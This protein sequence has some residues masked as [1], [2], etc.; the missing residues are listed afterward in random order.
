MSSIVILL[1]VLM[2]VLI[3]FFY[4]GKK[5]KLLVKQ[6]EQETQFEQELAKAQIEMREMTLTYV[7]QELHDDIGQ[8]LSVAKMMNNQLVSKSNGDLK[9][10][11]N[12]ISALLGESIQ[13]IRNM[14]KTY[15]RTD[16]AFWSYWIFKTWICE[17]F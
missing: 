5:T 17:N 12:E 2:M 14:S 9:E 16:R 4:I 3:Y 11:L 6:K 13:D 7:G 10:N 8:Q 1:L 15:H